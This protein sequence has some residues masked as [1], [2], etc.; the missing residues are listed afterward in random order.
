[1]TIRCPELRE[2]TF[3]IKPGE[4]RRLRTGW[5]DPASRVSFDF[6]NGEGLQFDNLAYRQD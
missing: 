5:Q 6:K 1:V 2:V 4:L 3:I